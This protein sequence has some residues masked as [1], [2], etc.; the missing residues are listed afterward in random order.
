M[1]PLSL[2]TLAEAAAAAGGGAHPASIGQIIY[3]LVNFLIFAYLIKRFALPVVREQLRA[4]RERIVAGMREA[5]EEKRCAIATALDY[6][7]R[8][9]SLDRETRAIRDR[10]AAAAEA[11]NARLLQAAD[12]LARKIS[13]DAQF[14]AE[15]ETKTARQQLRAE[16]ASLAAQRAAESIRR[17]IGDEDHRRIVQWFLRE[18]AAMGRKT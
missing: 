13:A 6:R 9:E 8:L 16:I 15:Q 5:E 2:F 12:G 7:R 10:L 1:T 14:M 3:P 17:E 18:V 4:R 11:E